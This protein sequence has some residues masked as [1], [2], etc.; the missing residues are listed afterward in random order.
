MAI[1]AVLFQ[2]QYDTIIQTYKRDSTSFETQRVNDSVYIDLKM[3]EL[4]KSNKKL[5]RVRKLN[6][7][8]NGAFLFG[9]SVLGWFIRKLIFN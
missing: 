3:D 2:K 1:R 6:K 4:N 9:G 8:K 7:I 5:V